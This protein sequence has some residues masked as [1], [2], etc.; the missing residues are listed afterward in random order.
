MLLQTEL[1][2]S[3]PFGKR[4]EPEFT[5]ARAEV[6]MAQIIS[7]PIGV[8]PIGAYWGQPLKIKLVASGLDVV[9]VP[10]H[11]F[12]CCPFLGCLITALLML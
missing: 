10:H 4:E 1:D 7:W 2:V 6:S 9:E 8:W 5:E 11:G 12:A 3:C